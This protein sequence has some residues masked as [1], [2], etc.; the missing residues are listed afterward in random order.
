MCIFYYK[1]TFVCYNDCA[2]YKI[3]FFN[4]NYCNNYY[5]ILFSDEISFLDETTRFPYL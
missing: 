3:Y 2:I 4:N 5:F 1:K